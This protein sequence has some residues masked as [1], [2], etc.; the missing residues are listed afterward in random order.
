MM[1]SIYDAR[2][3]PNSDMPEIQPHPYY[4]PP[5]GAVLTSVLAAVGRG[6]QLV[7][8]ALRRKRCICFTTLFVLVLLVPLVPMVVI[9]STSA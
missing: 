4:A 7:D 5:T 9:L 1:S 2:N 3:L 8:P 6:G